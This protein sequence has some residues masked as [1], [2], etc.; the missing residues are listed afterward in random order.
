MLTEGP[1]SRARA[2]E[3][4]AKVTA[5]ALALLVAAQ[6]A[7]YVTFLLMV[8]AHGLGAE[9]NP[10]VAAIAGHGLVDAHRR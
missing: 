7:D 1:G 2:H 8:E 3:G 9:R 10:I 4:V 5:V 6:A